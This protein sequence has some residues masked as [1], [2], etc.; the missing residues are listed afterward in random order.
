MSAS[1]GDRVGAI[2]GANKEEKVVDFLGF[3]VYLGALPVDNE[4][5]GLMAEVR[6]EFQREH[7][8]LASRPG[9]GNPKIQLDSGETVYGCE[10]WWGGETNVK[11]RLDEY[12]KD[13]WTVREVTVASF[14]EFFRK[15]EAEA[16]RAAEAARADK[17]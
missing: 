8:E 15:T 5:V 3:G 16:V 11:K 4:A 14:R 10:C 2:L 6:R 7:P 17:G 9:T 13:G 12:R 1:V